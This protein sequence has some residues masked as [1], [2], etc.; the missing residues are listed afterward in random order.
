MESKKREIVVVGGGPAGLIAAKTAAEKDVDVLL[1]ESKDKIGF[2]EHCAGLLS[3]KGLKSLN[4][5]SIPSD[6]FQNKEIIGARL[7]SPSGKLIEV[8]KKEPTAC[9]VNRVKFN[10]FLS[11]LA[12][13]AGVDIETSS[14]VIDI[15]RK[16]SLLEL[17]LG[18]KNSFEKINSKIT[19]LAE[20]RFPK[21]NNKVG[22]PIP[23]RKRM[24]YTSQ[25]Y[26]SNVSGIDKQYVE[27]YQ[28]KEYA[29]GFF[30]WIIPINEETA[31]VGLGSNS[32]PA[33]KQLNFFIKKHP[34]AK[35]KL[36]KSEINKK[37]S[38]AIPI[39]SYI[40][41]TFTDNILVV[42]DAASQTKPTT[43]GGVILGGI[44]AQIAGDVAANAI[45]SE[46]LSRKYLSNYSKLWKK[47]MKRNLSIMR[48]V[49]LYLNS[50]NNKEIEKLFTVINEPKLQPIFTEF[51]DV[52]EQ[53]TIV[54][55][56]LL[57]YKLWPFLL[58][59]GM[60]YLFTRK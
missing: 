30:A 43:G 49:R 50:L 59:T 53:K 27:L 14:R 54:F 33:S 4:L 37:S 35:K 1:F 47:E 56:L 40:S 32:I 20:G 46:N 55:R 15:K 8:Q 52:D 17:N 12:E 21:L 3:I 31:K 2:H 34:I 13:K 5:S 42:G 60:K 28:T 11:S 22:L 19:I 57:Y 7:Y 18:K 23:S 39:G 29:P 44:A 48:Q 51:G 10:L 6:I 36:N 24:I 16:N 25:Y 58:K 9:V 38:G 26:M 45:K 41:R